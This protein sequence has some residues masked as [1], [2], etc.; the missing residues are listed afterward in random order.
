MSEAGLVQLLN[1]IQN[2]S[3]DIQ[4]IFTTGMVNQEMLVGRQGSIVQQRIDD[5]APTQ[6]TT[7]PPQEAPAK[8][9]SVLPVTLPMAAPREDPT[10]DDV[11]AEQ[12]Y[13]LVESDNTWLKSP[14]GEPT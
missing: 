9:A 7:Q 4:T 6:V 2:P 14:R 12:D 13:P 11:E 10:A 8:Q 1:I 5:A 3:A